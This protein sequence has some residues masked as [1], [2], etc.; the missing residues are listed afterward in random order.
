MINANKI[1]TKI[2]FDRINTKIL[3]KDGNSVKYTIYSIKEG[4]A[5]GIETVII[6]VEEISKNHRN[7]KHFIRI[8]SY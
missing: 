2:N 1:N 3:D 8:R 4:L 5:E 7:T 6:K